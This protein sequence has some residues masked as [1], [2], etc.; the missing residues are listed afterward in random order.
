MTEQQDIVERL[1]ALNKLY[2]EDCRMPYSEAGDV[3]EEAAA[4]ITRL[5]EDLAASEAAHRTM[6]RECGK[7]ISERDTLREQLR[8]AREGL[9][10]LKCGQPD[11][12]S[13]Y[14]YVC[15]L[16]DTLTRM[17]AFTPPA[18]RSSP[19]T[20]PAATPPRGRSP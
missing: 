3:F 7:L 11:G 6:V 18:D 4:E 5:R 14:D 20:A 15:F 19:P 2:W 13:V 8:I 16:I 1:D 10:E 12:M 9:E 17:D